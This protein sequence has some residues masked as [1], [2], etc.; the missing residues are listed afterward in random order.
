MSTPE[1]GG[2]PQVL[3]KA[4]FFDQKAVNTDHADSLA[5][6]VVADHVANLDVGGVRLWATSA[7]QNAVAATLAKRDT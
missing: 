3:L 6:V 2:V 7:D 1:E 5:I 4:Q